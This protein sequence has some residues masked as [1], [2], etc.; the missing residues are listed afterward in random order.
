MKNYK[1]ILVMGLPGS[2]KSTLSK[3][4]AKKI[5]AFWLNADQIRKKFNDWDFSL[6][7]RSRQAKRMFNLSEEII[8]KGNIVV[9]DFICPTKKIEMNLN[10][11]KLFGWIQLRKVDLMIRIKCLKILRLLILESQ[12]KMQ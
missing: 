10:L 11:I 6:E 2:G 5:G 8:S 7:G 4:L 12:K 9:A 1:K 3:I